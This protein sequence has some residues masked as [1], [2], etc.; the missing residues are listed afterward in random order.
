M[1]EHIKQG[2][3]GCRLVLWCVAE[4]WSEQLSAFHPQC[5]MQV[6]LHLHFNVHFQFAH[7]NPE[8]TCHNLKK[9]VQVVYLIRVEKSAY[10]EREDG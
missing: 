8:R 4:N 1:S 9:K 2:L 5:I 10:Q 3:R 7:K 6:Q